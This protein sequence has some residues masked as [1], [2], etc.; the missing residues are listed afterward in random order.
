MSKKIKTLYALDRGIAE[1]EA[2]ECELSESEER[3]AITALYTRCEDSVLR[4]HVS[5]MREWAPPAALSRSDTDV[6]SEERTHHD[7]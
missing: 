3:A 5:L 7:Y 4:E 1:I 2:R 6:D